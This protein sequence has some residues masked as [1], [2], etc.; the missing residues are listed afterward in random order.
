MMHGNTKI[1]SARIFKIF[2]TALYDL[3]LQSKALCFLEVVTKLLSVMQIY[4]VLQRITQI[5]VL[6]GQNKKSNIHFCQCT[7]GSNSGFP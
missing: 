5:S 7:R 1:K 6:L 2:L 3:F 4:F